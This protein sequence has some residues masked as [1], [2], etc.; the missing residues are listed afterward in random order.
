MNGVGLLFNT[1]DLS[2]HAVTQATANPSAYSPSSTVAR[3]PRNGP[4][5]GCSGMNAAISRAYTGSL[6][7]QVAKGATKIVAS[8][9]R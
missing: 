9:S 1:V 7:E 6:A 2:S 5:S 4:R 8:R 3:V